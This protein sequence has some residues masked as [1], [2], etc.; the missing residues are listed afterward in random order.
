MVQSNTPQHWGWCYPSLQAQH[1]EPWELVLWPYSVKYLLCLLHCEGDTSLG[2]TLHYGGAQTREMS[3]LGCKYRQEALLKES[4]EKRSL[5]SWVCG[6]EGVLCS[7]L[8]P[9]QCSSWWAVVGKYLSPSWLTRIEA[10]HEIGLNLLEMHLVMWKCSAW[11]FGEG[12]SHPHVMMPMAVWDIRTGQADVTQ[13]QQEDQ[14]LL[15]W[16][17]EDLCCHWIRTRPK[18]TVVIPLWLK[19][20]TSFRKVALK[21]KKQKWK[22]PGKLEF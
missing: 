11:L 22:N 3:S 21:P 7:R 6:K 9:S 10:M 5:W 13:H 16:W 2:R 1:S 20:D 12:F 19:Y 15:E 18:M 14:A 8:F 17:L 4:E